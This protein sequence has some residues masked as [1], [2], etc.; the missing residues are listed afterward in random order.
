MSPPTLVEARP[1][2]AEPEAA[3]R[4]AGAHP[5]VSALTSAMLLWCAFPPVGWGW[6]AW[7]ALVPLFLLVVRGRRPAVAYAGAWAGGMTFWLLSV[8]W[9][10]LIVSTV[11]RY[12]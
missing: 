1:K 3:S 10:S 7:V 11:C 6:L 8:Q 12:W 5:V 2:A 9:I 4:T